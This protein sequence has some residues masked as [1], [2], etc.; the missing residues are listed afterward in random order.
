MYDGQLPSP[1][2]YGYEHGWWQKRQCT[3][4]CHYSTFHP[5]MQ[6]RTRAPLS[7][8]WWRPS[9]LSMEIPWP[10]VTVSCNTVGWLLFALLFCLHIPSV[11]SR[12]GSHQ[13]RIM[14][15]NHPEIRLMQCPL[16]MIQCIVW[17]EFQSRVGDDLNGRNHVERRQTDCGSSARS[18]ACRAQRVLLR[19]NILSCQGPQ[20]W[21][22]QE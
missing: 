7:C 20:K 6:R 15:I 2:Q 18:H 8:L 11:S 22:D 10:E 13:C 16:I 9:N 12:M 4:C 19:V 5:W 21:P 14:S 1:W 17:A 3:P